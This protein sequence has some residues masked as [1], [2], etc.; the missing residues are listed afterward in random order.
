[1]DPGGEA[2][3]GPGGREGANVK[4][5]G[6]PGAGARPLVVVV[7]GSECTGKTTLARSLAARYDTAVAAEYSRDYALARGGPLTEADVDPIAR[8]TMRAAD[9]AI[10]EA[11]RRGR[12]LAVLDTDLASTLVYAWHYYGGAPAWVQ[13]EARARRGD[14]YLLCH[15]DVPWVAD[16]VRDRPHLREQLHA[17]FHQRLVAL[18]A[19]V[20]HVHGGW[21]DRETRATAAVDALLAARAHP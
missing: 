21:A 19:R 4:P 3:V 1:M 14:L 12:P 9:A 13:K 8:G 2:M 15:P 10:A 5:G 6:D 16:P 18:G 20:A 17:L 7:T 11:L